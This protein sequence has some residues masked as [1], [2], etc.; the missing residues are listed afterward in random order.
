MKANI[1]EIDCLKNMY[2]FESFIKRWVP[3]E[4]RTSQKF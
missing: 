2:V 1:N 4:N 3:K